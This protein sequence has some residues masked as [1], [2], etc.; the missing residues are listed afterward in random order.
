[1]SQGT[2]W[3]LELAFRTA[4]IQ[5]AG[6]VGLDT[7][8]FLNVDPNI[9]NDDT[10]REGLTVQLLEAH[11]LHPERIVFEITE[12]SAIDR[13]ELFQAAIEHY[14]SQGYRIA[15]D[16]MGAGYS[17]LNAICHI[18]PGFIKID[19]ALIRSINQDSFKQAVVKSFVVLANLTG[20]KLIAEGI[21]NHG[22]AAYPAIPWC[23]RRA[24]ISVW[25][26]GLRA[27]TAERACHGDP[28]LPESCR[29]PCCMPTTPVSSVKSPNLSAPFS[30]QDRCVDVRRHLEEN[31]YEGVCV[32]D[33]EHIAGMVMRNDLNESLS[34]QY[35]YSLYAN[36]PIARILGTAPLVVDSSTP[37]GSVTELALNRN[38]LAIY[39]NIVVT[40]NGRYAGMVSI[41]RLLRHAWRLSAATRWN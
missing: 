34:R 22:G 29:V 19:M 39:H 10:F 27:H 2:L 17:N 28:A 40:R 32:L 12:R 15:I 3:E 20:S 4:A 26:T 31:R 33:G 13:F 9:V 37:I 16:D 38:G 41:I 35:G 8:L 25:K 7:L 14:R 21:E 30:I 18:H 11:G 23:A 5:R 6:E 1:M 24:G 36:R